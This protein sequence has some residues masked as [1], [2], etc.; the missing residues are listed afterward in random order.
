MCQT[1]ERFFS[2][3]PGGLYA[4]AP[5]GTYTHYVRVATRSLWDAFFGDWR[6]DDHFDKRFW[7]KRDPND[8]SEDTLGDHA[9]V[10]K[11]DKQ[12]AD[13]VEAIVNFPTLWTLDC[14]LTV[15]IA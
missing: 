5:P 4:M 14:D 9:L 2:L 15:Q 7:R 13:A 8:A 11:A 10:V 3:G 12:P 1:I 6:V